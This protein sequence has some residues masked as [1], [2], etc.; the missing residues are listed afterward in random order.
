MSSRDPG[1]DAGRPLADPYN[2]CG[3][4]LKLSR[5]RGAT[6]GPSPLLRG[7]LTICHEKERRRPRAP[8][9]YWHWRRAPK[10][11]ALGK[12]IDAVVDYHRCPEVLVGLV[13]LC[14]GLHALSLSSI[15]LVG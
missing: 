8:P 1:L 3:A 11:E 13:I 5:V 4:N 12:L 15:M 14:G 6:P 2:A 10:A 7:L 9:A